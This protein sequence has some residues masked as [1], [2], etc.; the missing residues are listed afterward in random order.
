MQSRLS[1]GLVADI[2]AAPYELRSKI[3]RSKLGMMPHMHV[4]GVVVDFLA[5]QVQS[6]I[7]ELEGALYR[8]M[9]HVSLHSKPLTIDDAKTVLA[10]ILRANDQTVTV[11]RVQK[12]VADYYQV[13]LAD[14]SSAS[15][16]R[17]I[18]RP[19]QVAM[20]LAKQYTVR[21]LAEIGARFGRKDHTTVMHAI[22][23][24]DSLR[25]LDNELDNDIKTLEKR[26]ITA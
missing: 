22:K 6:N 25:V 11:S 8:V 10:D 9:A 4:P 18:V 3:L 26:I 16:A 19:R 12:Q 1:G 7:R 5:Q 13:R 21:S 23:R 15:R 17:A 2:H 24:I 20:Y 14:M